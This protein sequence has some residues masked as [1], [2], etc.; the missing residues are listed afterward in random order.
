MLKADEELWNLFRE[1]NRLA[2]PVAGADEDSESARDAAEDKLL[3]ELGWRTEEFVLRTFPVFN[4]ADAEDLSQEVVMEVTR[5]AKKGQLKEDK[6]IISL[7]FRIAGWLA[8]NLLQ[9]RWKFEELKP[10]SYN[11]VAPLRRNPELAEQ[12]SWVIRQLDRREQIAIE[13]FYYQQMSIAE[14]AE[15]FHISA[16]AVEGTLYRARKNFREIWKQNEL[17]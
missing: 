3:I 8:W 10:E 5:M 6:S 1:A 14:I 9:D 16:R 4:K 15:T 11:P 12:I 17:K 7:C 13:L 2:G